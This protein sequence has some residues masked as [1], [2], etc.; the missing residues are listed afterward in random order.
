MTKTYR[1]K[2]N[3][4]SIHNTQKFINLISSKNQSVLKNSSMRTTN[5]K[6]KKN[7]AT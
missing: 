5:L 7:H 3:H 2:I 1:R 4:F 6:K